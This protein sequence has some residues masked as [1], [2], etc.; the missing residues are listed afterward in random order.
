MFMEKS[1]LEVLLFTLQYKMNTQGKVPCT[2]REQNSARHLLGLKKLK[3][4][5]H[6]REL[7]L[8]EKSSGQRKLEQLTTSFHRKAGM[9]KTWLSGTNVL[10]LK[11]TLVSTLPQLR[12]L[13]RS[14]STWNQHL[15]L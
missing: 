12:L 13:P 11:T 15:Y 1:N 5:K 4:A 2:S 6:E 9:D 10:S 8:E 14:R 7:A 3:K